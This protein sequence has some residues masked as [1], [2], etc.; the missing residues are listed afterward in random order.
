[1]YTV[2]A[3]VEDD[4]TNTR[5]TGVMS[6]NRGDL[7]KQLDRAFGKAVDGIYTDRLGQH[8]WIEEENK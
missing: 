5:N 2:M 1:M 7:V 3:S 8:F 4:L 6:D